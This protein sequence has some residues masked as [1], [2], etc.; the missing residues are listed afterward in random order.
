M[1]LTIGI[2][3]FCI[4]RY[5]QL[6]GPLPASLGAL[7]SLVYAH[8]GFNEFAG[9]IPGAI[10]N[11]SSLFDLGPSTTCFCCPLFGSCSC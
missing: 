9:S 8:L 5:N 1:L 6:Q 2:C 7:T 4:S 11:L 10:G 3:V